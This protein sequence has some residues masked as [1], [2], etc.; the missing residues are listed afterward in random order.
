MSVENTTKEALA[1]PYLPGP[2]FPP[3]SLFDRA[4]R[5]A[6]LWLAWEKVRAN[7]GAAG[8]DGMTVA[9]YAPAAHGR[10]S[11]LS[12]DLRNG[13][14]RPGPARR[15]FIPKPDGGVRPL[16]IP[17]V[18]DRIAQAAVAIVLTPLL[19]AEFE[20]S[21][22]AYRP[23]RSVLQAVARVAKHRRAGFRWVVDGDITRYFERVPHEGLLSRLERSVSDAP[24]VDL[25]ATWLEHHSHEGRGLPQGSPLSPLLANLY[26]DEVDEA[27]EGR[28]LR[29]VRFADDFL[30]LCKD[31]ALAAGAKARMAALLAEY[32]LE[33]N[34][35]KSRITSFDQGVRFLGH[36]FVKGMVVKEIPLDDMP[37]ED[38][39]A[40]AE[41][42]TAAVT[43]A[44]DASVPDDPGAEAAAPPGRWAARQ[45][46]MYVLQPGRRLA[47][48]GE[49]FV[50]R[51]AETELARVAPHRVD[52]IELGRGVALDV[53]ALDLAAATDTV[54]L[55][56][57]GWGRA[58]GR[59]TP[60]GS[61]RAK[62]QLA[63]AA[64]VLDPARRIALARRIVSGRILSQRT[65][66][67][68]LSRGKPPPAFKAAAT[69]AAPR[70]R[71]LA[72]AAALDPKL[73]TTA[74]LM[75]QEGAAAAIYWPLLA[76]SLDKP[77]F[78]R[79]QRRRRQGE[80]P[81]NAVLDVLSGLLARD[82]EVAL[83]RH[84]LHTGFAVLH[85]AEDGVEAL[86]HDLMEE[87]RAPVVE[88]CALALFG[89]RALEA[90][91]FDAWG[92]SWRLTGD[93]YSACIRGYEA[94]VARPVRGQRSGESM[95]WRGVMEEQALAYAAQCEDDTP[96]EPYRMD[97]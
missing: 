31:E 13:R 91:H 28:G 23:G 20:D 74:A 42:W 29:L 79:G 75:G 36:L 25:I 39:L 93:G 92:D 73:G 14:Y 55:R 54:V 68:R 35:E 48:A 86:V 72:R 87:F 17:P 94:W 59:W 30:I 82:L 9:R 89:R 2:R 27:I 7:N 33:L 64:L 58:L 85:A 3:D 50:V 90:K 97:Y 15:V 84:G 47:T 32:G 18:Q 63:Q 80:D 5:H 4:T 38:A 43:E 49:S 41:Q 71:R 76:L 57:D 88:A 19:D 40:A 22:F 45:R 8:G 6:T 81:V 95:L 53:E 61:G 78:F 65:L 70:L 77:E 44:P 67:K 16:D 69:E 12:H 46:V 21:S 52:R 51:E 96:Y 34:A 60:A 56:T 66:L 24:L 26:L 83:E 11:R 1:Q 62:R 10:L 37:P